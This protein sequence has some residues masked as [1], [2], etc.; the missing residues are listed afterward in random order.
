MEVN[1]TKE[2]LKAIRLTFCTAGRKAMLLLKE[3]RIK[4]QLKFAFFRTI[5]PF[6]QRELTFQL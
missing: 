5:N 6:E 2:Q 3:K 1:S 4:N